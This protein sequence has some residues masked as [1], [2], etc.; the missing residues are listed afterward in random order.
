MIDIMP[1]KVFLI[2]ALKIAVLI[3]GFMDAYKY[4]MMAQKVS[5]L[6]A[7]G[8]ISRAFLLWSIINRVILLLYVW[9]LLG[10]KIL[11]TTCVIALYT[12]AEAFY[13]VY[14]HYPYRNRGLNNFKKPSV[15][16]FIK[17]IYF[18]NKYGKKL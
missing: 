12:M 18:P 5:R 8:Q 16:A 3:T 15:Y 11:I 7:S 9:L 2:Y 10:D 1:L 13:Y 6:K 17:D 14:I 4:K